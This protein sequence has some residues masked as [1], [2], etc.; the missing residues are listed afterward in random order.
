M[1]TKPIRNATSCEMHC[2][3]HLVSLAEYALDALYA[4]KKH[5]VKLEQARKEASHA[6]LE[7][8]KQLGDELQV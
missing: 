6:I 2:H 3:M 5:W 1:I 4:F 8:Y 7:H